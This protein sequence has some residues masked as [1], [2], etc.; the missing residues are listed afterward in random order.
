MPIP[1]V[2]II[3]PTFNRS[4]FIGQAIYSALRQTF[5]DFEIIVIDDGSTDGTR[6][7]VEQFDDYRI[8]YYYQKNRG[9][10]SALNLGIQK[11][12]G[13]FI[14]R[15]DSDDLFLP[16]KIES[17]IRVFRS[18]PQVGLVYTQA[19]NV[20]SELNF[21]GL[22]PQQH[23]LP[24]NLLKAL[25]MALFPPSQSIMFR[26]RCVLRTGFFNEK[27]HIAED[28]DFCIRMARY[29][30]FYYIERPLVLIRKH[31]AM[32]TGNKLETTRQILAVLEKHKRILADGEGYS[33]LSP[34]YYG[35][36]RQLFYHN[37][38]KNARNAFSESVSYNPLNINS[39]LFYLFAYLPAKFL[40]KLKRSN[41]A[42]QVS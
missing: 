5:F 25:R 18:K 36:G 1:T 32:I 40:K 14:A 6:N 35:L 34:H 20:D 24:Q 9:V 7:V 21:I 42:A 27:I 3:I 8:R 37:D 39:L 10:S 13:E 38:F 12:K 26:K 16:Q 15:L 11:S 4:K 2:S 30:S 22:Y 28:W 41:F 33:W 17:Q 19:F 31:D 23:K 29:Y